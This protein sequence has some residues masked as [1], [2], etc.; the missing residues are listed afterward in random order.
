MS[1]QGNQQRS[2]T[3]FQ[4]AGKT[5]KFVP[6][7]DAICAVE[8]LTGASFLEILERAR[9]SKVRFTDYAALL[10]EFS[11]A[12]GEEMPRAVIAE[13]MRT[14][15]AE[16]NRLAIELICGAFQSPE[17]SSANPPAAA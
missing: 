7:F 8:G 2:E 4:H 10:A 3:R 17:D 5:W 16:T 14:R 9:Q 12:G 15:F 11:R 13:L 6:E 1:K